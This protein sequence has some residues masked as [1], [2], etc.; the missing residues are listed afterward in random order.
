MRYAIAIIA[1]VTVLL[2]S[3]C[4]QMGPL[5]EPIETAPPAATA[6]ATPAT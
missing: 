2:S 4:G 1:T 5:Y 6:P 3:G